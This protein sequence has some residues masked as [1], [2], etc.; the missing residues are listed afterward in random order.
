MNESFSNERPIDHRFQS[1]RWIASQK[2]IAVIGSPKGKRCPHWLRD[3]IWRPPPTPLPLH[4]SSAEF[5][6][7]WCWVRSVPVQSP[8]PWCNSC[9][10]LPDIGSNSGQCQAQWG[11]RGTAGSKRVTLRSPLSSPYRSRSQSFAT[12]L[13]SHNTLDYWRERH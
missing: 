13:Q 7:L 2:Q 5:Q 4:H 3:A 8:H 6:R 12:D 9:P 1:L 10:A 11:R